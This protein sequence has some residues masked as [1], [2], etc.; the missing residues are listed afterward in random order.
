[1]F[2]RAC[3]WLARIWLR[4]ENLYRSNLIMSEKG[5]AIF[6]TLKIRLTEEG[7]SFVTFLVFVIRCVSVFRCFSISFSLTSENFQISYTHTHTPEQFLFCP[8]RKNLN[9]LNLADPQNFQKV[10]I[11]NLALL[12]QNFISLLILLYSLSVI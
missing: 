10:F 3:L 7:A 8:S 5:I 12:S 1:M 9:H 2:S 4:E 11:K 6:V